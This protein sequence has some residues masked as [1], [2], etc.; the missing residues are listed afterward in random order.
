MDNTTSVPDTLRA[1][2]SIALESRQEGHERV[3][4]LVAQSERTHLDVATFRGSP[5]WS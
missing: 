3:A 2:G 1:R 4:L 5:P